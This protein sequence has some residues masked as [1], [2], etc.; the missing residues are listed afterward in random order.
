MKWDRQPYMLISG[1]LIMLTIKSH[2]RTT[3]HEQ[4]GLINLKTRD[5]QQLHLVMSMNTWKSC[6]NNIHAVKYTQIF[7]HEAQYSSLPSKLLLNNLPTQNEFSHLLHSKR[8]SLFMVQVFFQVE[9]G[10]KEYVGH[11]AALQI[12]QCYLAWK[13]QH[14]HKHILIQIAR[15][16]CWGSAADGKDMKMIKMGKSTNSKLTLALTWAFRFN[17]IKHLAE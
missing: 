14:M 13:M 2:R 9:E 7:L 4:V 17:Q 16:K 8:V 12:T 5:L 15:C 11:S 10:V 1:A 3:P 6:T